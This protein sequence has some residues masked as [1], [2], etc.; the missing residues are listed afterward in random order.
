MAALAIL[1][2]PSRWEPGPIAKVKMSLAS[3]KVTCGCQPGHHRAGN[4]YSGS[5]K[6]KLTT[7][8]AVLMMKNE[9]RQH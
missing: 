8:S 1:V 4:G 2:G 3:S 9:T 5:L 6:Q 7:T